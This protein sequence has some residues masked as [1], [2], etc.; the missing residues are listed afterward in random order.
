MSNSG[1]LKEKAI[2]S[3]STTMQLSSNQVDR[4]KKSIPKFNISFPYAAQPDIIR[5]NQKDVYYQQ[6]LGE[7]M[8]NTF[9]MFFGTRLQHQYQKEVNVISDL[10]YFCL[11]ALLGTQTLGEEYCD[12]M[13]ISEPTKQFPSASASISELRKRT[14]PSWKKSLQRTQQIHNTKYDRLRDSIYR[15]LP[16]LQI[17][18]KNNVHSVHLAIFYFYGAYYFI[19]KRATGIRYIFTRQ[20]GPHEQRIGYEILGF[21]L[22]VQFIIQ[23]Y[24][25]QKSLIKGT[26]DSLFNEV[27]EEE[28]S[29]LMVTSTEG[30][31]PQEI[32]ARKCILCLSPRKNTTATP[33]GHLFC[34][35]C[36]VDCCNNKPECPL[37]RQYVNISHLL[38]IYNY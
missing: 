19:S 31:T 33:C 8:T 4:M 26:D 16:K 14:K 11:T 3:T 9:R 13:Q 29:D 6:I 30:L 1:S 17:L 15:L 7:Q 23:A 28:E 32:A 25:F 27:E 18:L 35:T 2:P 10:F 24:R 5:A 37:C 34:W 38:P 20:L 12:I 22:V 36:I 21:L